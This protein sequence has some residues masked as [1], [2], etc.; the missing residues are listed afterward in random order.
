MS[1]IETTAPADA[2]GE[3]REMYLR[4]QGKWGYVPNYARVF[5]ARP[6]LMPLWAELL[7]GIR[8][9]IEPR[10]FELATLAAAAALGSS[11]CA[12]AHGTALIRHLSPASVAAIAGAAARDEQL[13]PLPELS[14]A[15]HAIVRFAAR[16]ARRPA[17][18]DAADIDALRA[19]GL[20]DAEIFDLAATVAA[21]CF[22]AGLVESLGTRADAAYAGMQPELR[23]A[24]TMG[25]PI[26]TT[27]GERVAPA[28]SCLAGLPP[29]AA[30][31]NPLVRRPGPL[32]G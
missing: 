5:S 11:Y 14:P 26:A 10:R 29:R 18:I 17:R 20:H 1:F 7:A 22:F 3:L 21:R 9:H 28:D 27:P 32:P 31:R 24:L 19:A 8:R 30:L 13:P 23:D 25:R 12:L 4:Q 2:S 16:A 6:E 15:D